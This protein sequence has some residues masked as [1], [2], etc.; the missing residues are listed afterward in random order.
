MVASSPSNRVYYYYLLIIVCFGMLFLL[1]ALFDIPHP[2]EPV[3]STE[4]ERSLALASTLDRQESFSDVADHSEDHLKNDPAG[5]VVDEEVLARQRL[6]SLVGQ[7]RSA[8]RTRLGRKKSRSD[9]II[10]YYHH[11][12]DGD[13]AYRLKKLNFYIHERPVEPEVLGYQS[14]AVYYGDSVDKVDLQVVAH[15]LLSSGLPIKTIRPSKYKWKAHA[16]EIATDTTLQGQPTIR[17]AEI[18][19]LTDSVLEY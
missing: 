5:S 17:Y 13:A 7:Y 11:S 4:E 12:P 1:D 6:D 9:V 8:I 19:A 18:E 2:K 10:R 16:V 3:Y 15:T 14:N